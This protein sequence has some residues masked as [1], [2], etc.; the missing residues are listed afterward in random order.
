MAYRKIESYDEETTAKLA[1]HYKAILELIGED[2]SREGLLKTPERVAKAIQFLTNGY[3]QDGREIL[4][5]ALFE[6]KYSQMVLVKDIELY[7]TCEHHMLPFIGKA[8]VA[9][10]PN[11]RITG[12]SKI[13]RVVECYARRLQVQERLTTQI[14]ECIDSTLKP[15]G[16]AVVIEAAH[17]CMRLRGVQKEHSLTT[18]SAFSGAFLKDPRTREEFMHLIGQKLD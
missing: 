12:L 3:L 10:I 15:L 6:E 18:T 16:T 14:L 9:Y 11:G 1:E 8:H 5:G 7:S 13:A 4:M 2:P 17:T